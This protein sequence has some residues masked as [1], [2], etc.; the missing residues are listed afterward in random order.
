MQITFCLKEFKH[1]LLFGAGFELNVD[2]YFKAPG[3]PILFNYSTGTFEANFT[4]A[5]IIEG[6]SVT[7]SQNTT[8]SYSNMNMSSANEN[9]EI[10]P[11]SLKTSKS[12]EAVIQTTVR[13]KRTLFDSSNNQAYLATESKTNEKNN[14]SDEDDVLLTQ[15]L[16]QQEK[17]AAATDQQKS[18]QPPSKKIKSLVQSLFEDNDGESEDESYVNGH[19][20]DTIRR[21]NYD[22][23]EI[24]VDSNDGGGQRVVDGGKKKTISFVNFMNNTLNISQKE[25]IPKVGT[26]IYIE[27]TD[28]EED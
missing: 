8:L 6:I 23:I 3:R 27:E 16:D 1:L 19:K 22:E 12:I 4:L 28:S 13:N 24:D 20:D 17:A 7:P 25:E 14:S 10:A 2:V 26:S 21:A 15:M 11:S 9:N 18:Q 5:S